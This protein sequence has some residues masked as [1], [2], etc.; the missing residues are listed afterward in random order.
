MPLGLPGRGK[1]SSAKAKEQGRPNLNDPSSLIPGPES[2]PVNSY[3]NPFIEEGS[4]FID[5]NGNLDP[6][7]G[8]QHPVEEMAEEK[9]EE[10]IENFF[11]EAS[12][13]VESLWDKFMS[14]LSSIFS[15]FENN[16]FELLLGAGVVML[17]GLIIFKF[18]L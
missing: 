7:V 2:E 6:F 18:L 5:E 10:E 8:N 4:P 11:E 1:S 9:I 13:S 14:L 12:E 16:W 3:S 17:G 15:F